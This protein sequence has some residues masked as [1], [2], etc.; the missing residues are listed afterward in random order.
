MNVRH[1]TRTAK[2]HAKPP[3]TRMA[4]RIQIPNTR[5]RILKIN[6]VTHDPGSLFLYSSP[7]RFQGERNVFKIRE[8]EKLFFVT[9]NNRLSKWN[10]SMTPRV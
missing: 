7:I 1:P 3:K 9:E 6:V 8:N 4:V 5:I 10:I 2:K